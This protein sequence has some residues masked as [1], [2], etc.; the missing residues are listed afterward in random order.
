MPRPAKPVIASPA[1]A[2]AQDHGRD[3]RICGGKR[4]LN[5]RALGP[6]V[7]AFAGKAGRNRV[8]ANGVARPDSTRRHYQT[9]ALQ[10]G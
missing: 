7:P 9:T 10:Q 5:G 1:T 2:G 3:E 4:R 8:D 6:W